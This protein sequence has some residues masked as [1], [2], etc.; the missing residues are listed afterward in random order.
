MKFKVGWLVKSTKFQYLIKGR[1]TIPN[2]NTKRIGYRMFNLTT[3][4]DYWIEEDVAEKRYK[5]VSK[6]K[7]AEVLFG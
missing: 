3:K 7:A 6:A 2:R 1:G 4:C 5:V